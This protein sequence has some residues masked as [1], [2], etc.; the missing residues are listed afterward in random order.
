MHSWGLEPAFEDMLN[1]K[2]K[3][4]MKQLIS[5]SPGEPTQETPFLFSFILRPF[6]PL[7]RWQSQDKD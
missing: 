3:F 4:W 7:I 2:A 6:L 1:I 5:L